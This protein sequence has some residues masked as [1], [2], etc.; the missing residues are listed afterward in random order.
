MAFQEYS[1]TKSLPDMERGLLDF[2]RKNRIFEKSVEQN[3]E[4]PPFVF[5]EGPPTANAKPGIHHVLSRV[6]KDI[7]IRYQSQKGCHVPRKAG[8]DCHGLPVER[9]VE[10]N[11]GIST[12]AEIESKVGLAEFNRLCRESVLTY[13]KDW[14]NFTERMGFWIDLDA[15]YYTLHNSYIESVWS[16]LAIIWEKGLIYQDYKVVPYDP[17]MGATLSDAEVAQGYQTIDDPSLTVR[18]QIE[19]D[20]YGENASFLVWTTTPWTL[21]SNT[22]LAVAPDAEYVIVE[23]VRGEEET[24]PGTTERLILASALK[25]A[26][27]GNAE[28]SV[29][30][31]LPGRELVNVRYRRL[32]DWLEVDAAKKGWYVVPADFV[33]MDT[34]TGIVHMAPA[35]GA[36]DLEIGKKYDLPI[37]HGVGLDGLFV[38]NSPVAG[39]F[40]KDADKEIVSDLKE[41]GLVWKSERYSHEYPFG[42]RTGAPL[43]YYAKFAWYIRTTQ[44]R[45]ELI[46]NNATINWIPEHIKEG[47]FGNWLA[48]N[49]DWALSR[50]RYWGTPLPLWTDGEGRY[51]MVGS[52]A[53]L[54]QLVGRD[55]SEL[56]L[57]RPFVD[58]IEFND[59]ETG[60]L[61]RRVPEV[62][63]CWFDSGAMPHAQW[64]HPVRGQEQFEAAFPADFIT[65]A[66]DQT[67][68]WFY[69]LLAISTMIS[70][71]APF[72]NVICLGHVVDPKGEKMSK[73]KGNTVAP[74]AV[75]ETYG[76]D[77]LRWYF[78]TGAPPGNSRRVGKPGDPHDPVKIVLGYLKTIMNS[79]SFLTLYANVD[80]IVIGADWENAPVAGALPFAK[81]P[82]ID[83]WVLSLL[84]RLIAD[85]TRALDEYDSYAAGR[86]L[87]EFAELL[88]NWYIRRNRRRFWKGEPDADK[89][90]AYDT[91]YRCL[92]VFARLIAPF[93]PFLAEDIFRTL[94]TNAAAKSG[95]SGKGVNA[96]KSPPESVHLTAWPVPDFENL[97]N[98]QILEEGNVVQRTAS[99]GHAARKQSGIKVRQPL[100][101]IMIH[102]SRPED[103]K[104]VEQCEDVL[105]D[106]LNIKA[107]EY[108]DDSAGILDYRAKPNLPRVGKRLGRAV[109]DVQAYFQKTSGREIAAKLKRGENLEIP[110]GDETIVLEGEDVLLESISKEGSSAVEG[111]GILVALDTTL[112]EELIREG[113]VRDIVRNVQELRKS[114]GLDLTDRIVL[115]I[116]GSET[117]QAAALEFQGYIEAETLARL[118]RKGGSGAP[119]GAIEIVLDK[120][121]VKLSIWKDSQAKVP[122]PTPT[123]TPK[124]S[125]VPPTMPPESASESAKKKPSPEPATASVAPA[126]AAKK[127]AKSPAPAAKK[128]VKSSA[129]AAKK[130]V[131]SSAPAAKKVAKSPAPAAK[132]VAKKPAPTAKKVAKKPAPAAKKVAKSP[133][134]AAKKVAKK[135]APAAKKVAKKPAPAAK[136]VVKKPAPAPKKVVKSPAPAAKKVV[137]KP[138]R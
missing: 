34:G 100:A 22:A 20:R 75:F 19:D 12:K 40:F 99:L 17:V 138:K 37:I 2:W 122:T 15:A 28:C 68:G 36:D 82:E 109:R 35:Y 81:R 93:V 66:V 32:I 48:N 92:T 55:L 137:K 120:E 102:L 7:Y 62:I 123:P 54:S 71:R 45:D 27:L 72:K 21:P 98:E 132:K 74:E 135:P 124:S 11:L 33:T 95:K 107:I 52:V 125:P 4:G 8:W 86:A 53:E 121:P 133:A 131:K 16:L 88:S 111:S 101:R 5:F 30:R 113:L 29:V 31:T 65:E 129:P 117:I 118:D 10:K 136:K 44:L 105:T 116:D 91:L 57:H 94:V 80:K 26:V 108:L 58:E 25:D 96:P 43:I 87:E 50:E 70:G 79:V 46:K 67:R 115:K 56:D 126:P 103:R 3:Q 60:K 127:V 51:R 6:Y 38:L 112:T 24:D 41:R 42:Y 73:S 69:T 76:A 85:V 61:M 97:Y 130:V 128:V 83:R 77:A 23:R 78:L 47:R 104:A 134:P 13:I 64:G 89:L 1:H 59:P 9:E 90:S 39:K 110:A 14:S 114:S 18:F 49:R 84:Q 63:D 106:E 119:A